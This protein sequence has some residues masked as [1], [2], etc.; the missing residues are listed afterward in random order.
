MPRK[1]S[2]EVKS[3]LADADIDSDDDVVIDDEYVLPHDVVD[4]SR[5]PTPERKVPSPPLAAPVVAQPVDVVRVI[6]VRA[7]IA[8]PVIVQ[9]VVPVQPG[10]VRPVR[11]FFDGLLRDNTY[12]RFFALAPVALVTTAALTL[13]SPLVKAAAVVSAVGW[14][15]CNVKTPRTIAPDT[16]VVWSVELPAPSVL[17]VSDRVVKLAGSV[18]AGVMVSSAFGTLGS[19]T[20]STICKLIGASELPVTVS[21]VLGSA[22]HVAAAAGIVLATML[23]RRREIPALTPAAA[24]MLPRQPLPPPAFPDPANHHPAPAF[25]LDPGLLRH[26][27]SRFTYSGSTTSTVSEIV[28]FVE[29]YNGHKDED[30]QWDQ[31][32][33]DGQVVALCQYHF[34]FGNQLLDHFT[35]VAAQDEFRLSRD[36]LNTRVYA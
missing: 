14:S 29:Q 27:C 21:T 18:V 7:P 5:S 3:F 25:V 8:L 16:K 2:A 11:A 24:E 33:V 10:W 22:G 36:T 30:A 26:Y 31:G 34:S 20:V 6:P 1:R 28:H 32:N 12:S 9:P 35:Q 23:V 15:Y 17:P 19:S 4:Y 13:G